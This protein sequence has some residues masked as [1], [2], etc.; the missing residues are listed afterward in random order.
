MS[1]T[2]W[3]RGPTDVTGLSRV[4]TVR[5]TTTFGNPVPS[6][7]TT[8]PVISPVCAFDISGAKPEEKKSSG[9]TEAR[10]TPR[11]R[12]V[13]IDLIDLIGFPPF[14]SDRAQGQPAVCCRR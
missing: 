9:A 3:F 1:V 4:L 11:K 6:S 14:G 5:K 2:V 8:R 13:Y 7:V 10:R 12:G